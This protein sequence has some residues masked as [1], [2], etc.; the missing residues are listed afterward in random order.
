MKE[1]L[2]I[3]TQLKPKVYRFMADGS[4]DIIINE[5]SISIIPC[6]CFNNITNDPVFPHDCNDCIYLGRHYGEGSDIVV[7]DLYYCQFT[8]SR[9]IRY[10]KEG[11]EY[12]SKPFTLKDDIINSKYENIFK[13]MKEDIEKLRLYK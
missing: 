7:Y 3:D 6:E 13:M 4:F 11:H 2:T 5:N 12:V 10:G 8:K 1:I 9:I